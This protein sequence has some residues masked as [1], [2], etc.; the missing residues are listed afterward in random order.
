MLL[1]L[2]CL[3]Y[4]LLLRDKVLIAFFVYAEGLADAMAVVMMLMMALASAACP[5][6]ASPSPA[7]PAFRRHDICHIALA[8][9][10]A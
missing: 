1:S 6:T 2:L 4:A 3:R 7:A 5:P 9:D 8:G 10:A